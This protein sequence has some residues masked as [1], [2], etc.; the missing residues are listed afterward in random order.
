MSDRDAADRPDPMG[1]ADAVRAVDRSL[2]A[3]GVVFDYGARRVLDQVSI[4]LEAGEVV[5]LLGRN[6]AGKSTLLR[7]LLGLLPAHQ[8]QVRLDGRM[9]SSWRRRVL[10][11][12]LAYV[13]QA[14]AIPFPYSVREVVLMGRLA[15]N[16]W[17]AA[18]READRGAADAL[19]AR[20]GIAQLADRS[21]IEVSG[22]ERQ[23]AV[24][25][26]ALIQGARLLILDEPMAGL[27]FGRQ[28][29]LLHHL[30]ALAREGYGILMTTHHPEQALQAATRVAVLID[31]RIVADGRPDAVVTLA[32]IR[33][34]YDVDVAT[35]RSPSGQVGFQIND[36][37]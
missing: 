4:G 28:V 31:G 24:L 12:R 10:A 22:G 34:L 30:A 26:R 32:M 33:R 5:A 6:G 18:P 2:Q 20:F 9:L 27:D 37:R 29:R 3:R 11:S 23:L 17:L 36:R 8:G 19:L 13:P 25:A 35:F 15:A 21:C 16:G 7:V 14:Q 1:E